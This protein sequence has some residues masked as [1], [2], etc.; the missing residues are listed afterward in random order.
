VTLGSPLARMTFP[1]TDRPS[2]GFI[3]KFDRALRMLPDDVLPPPFSLSLEGRVEDEA[4]AC[5]SSLGPV[6]RFTTMAFAGSRALVGIPDTVVDAIAEFAFGG[7]GSDAMDSGRQV[8]AIGLSYADRLIGLLVD[9][10]AQAIPGLEIALNATTDMPAETMPI[11][12]PALALG[13]ALSVQGVPLGAIGLIVPLR[14]L[15][16]IEIMSL[17]P[18]M[19]SDWSKRLESA[20]AQ[21]RTQVRAV[22]ARPT[23]TAGEVARLL[24]GAVIPIPSLSEVALIANGYR[25]ATG[26]AEP[27]DGR[28]TIILNRTE[29]AG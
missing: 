24:P 6:T 8:T 25:V 3:D 19:D 29:I 14:A 27:R 21:A 5:V 28:V 20:V 11:R 18:G 13:F 7:D 15:A 26:V 17:G 9:A 1:A 16:R 10:V 2:S 12:V 4:G 22:L 23:L